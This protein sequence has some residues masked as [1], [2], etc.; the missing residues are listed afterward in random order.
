MKRNVIETVLGALVLTV[1][2]VFVAFTYSTANIGTVSG[3][4]VSAEFDRIGG[5]E[6]GS[7]VRIS[8]I[9]V[10]SIVDFKLDPDT[11]LAS[12]VMSIDEQYKLPMDTA[13]VIT[14]EGLLGGKFMSLEPGGD[15]ETI[16]AGGRIAYAQSTPSLEQLLGQVIFSL[17]KSTGGDTSNSETAPASP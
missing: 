11:Y 5:I 12:V 16:P 15:E 3:Y 14:S 7:D 4:T 13:A 2:A 6:I 1:A 9:K 17:T 10:G 8:G